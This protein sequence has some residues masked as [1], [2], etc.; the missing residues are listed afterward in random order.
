MNV[1]DLNASSS[2]MTTT[3][4]C[5]AATFATRFRQEIYKETNIHVYMFC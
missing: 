2:I 5:C 4:E 1:G 3:V